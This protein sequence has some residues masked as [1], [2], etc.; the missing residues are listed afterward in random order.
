MAA[1]SYAMAG[2]MREIFDAFRLAR[3]R[4]GQPV[5]IADVL[6]QLDGVEISRSLVSN[7]L[8]MLTVND[9]Q[10]GRWQN[11][12]ASNDLRSDQGHHH[13]LL[14]KH[15]ASNGA[16]SYDYY[17][18]AMHGVW[19]LFPDYRG[20]PR[21]V[22]ADPVQE[23]MSQ[24]SHEVWSTAVGDEDTREWVNRSVARRRGR[25]KF[26]AALL[27]AYGRACA[28]TDCE[29]VDVLEAA[30][31]KPARG[32]HTMVTHNGILLRADI[33]TFF[34]CGRLWI[35]DDF[36]IGLH[37]YLRA[38]EYSMLQGKRIR[39]PANETDRPH[40]EHLEHHRSWA[41]ARPR[42]MPDG[43]HTK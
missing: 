1:D 43:G 2:R 19:E 25:P 6:Q 15:K 33:H 31:I 17:D 41:M 27:E 29:I 18:L 21:K 23:E 42:R 3:S 4:A 20:Q 22:D 39:L 37:P 9:L 34:D 7:Y 13:D 10:R 26:R 14:F 36:T 11:R 24:A 38:S 40:R 8:G 32:E 35:E 5:A 30:H 28:I 12:R 16:T